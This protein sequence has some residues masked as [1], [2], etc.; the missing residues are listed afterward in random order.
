MKE[1]TFRR[2]FYQADK[3]NVSYIG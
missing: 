3:T 1:A 2:L